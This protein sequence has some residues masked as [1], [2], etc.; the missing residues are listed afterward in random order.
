LLWKQAASGNLTRRARKAA[1]T[2]EALELR[3]ELPNLG[4]REG[5][6]FVHAVEFTPRHRVTRV[7]TV[8]TDAAC[9]LAHGGIGFTMIP[10]NEHVAGGFAVF[11]PDAGVLSAVRAPIG[12]WVFWP[13][14]AFGRGHGGGCARVV[15]GSNRHDAAKAETHGKQAT[16]VQAQ[17]RLEQSEQGFDKPNVFARFIR[18]AGNTLRCNK[19]NVSI[20]QGLDPKRLVDEYTAV[21][22]YSLAVRD[23]LCRES[24]TV[25]GKH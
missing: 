4:R 7:T 11:N 19:D 8:E 2:E 18:P 25:K 15:A 12:D 16:F 24:G 23:V 14:A 3:E 1:H 5:C 9:G 21:A 13:W 22:G 10:F 6:G 17:L 20:C